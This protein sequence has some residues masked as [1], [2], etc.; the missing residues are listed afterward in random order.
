MKTLL[1]APQVT[2]KSDSIYV[3]K[4]NGTQVN[5]YIFPEFEI[6]KNTIEARTKQEWHHH[7]KIEEVIIVDGGEL[8]ACWLGE[9]KKV[10]RVLIGEGDVI[11]VG[12]SVHTLENN[13]DSPVEFSVFRYVPDGVDKHDLIKSD[14]YP[15]IVEEKA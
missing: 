5:Y 11:R 13:S 1:E 10:R 8:N 14:R 2:K 6:H 15:D 12:A 3:D 9:D 7:K 4:K